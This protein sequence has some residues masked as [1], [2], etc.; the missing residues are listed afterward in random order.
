MEMATIGETLGL[1]QD[2]GD[3]EEVDKDFQKVCKAI[4]AAEGVCTVQIA[5]RGFWTAHP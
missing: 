4:K 1:V 2:V 3:A 5:V